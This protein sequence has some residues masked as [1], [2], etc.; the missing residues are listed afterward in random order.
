[1]RFVIS[2]HLLQQN[3]VEDERRPFLSEPNARQVISVDALQILAGG[4]QFISVVGMS[5]SV[6][7]TAACYRG[8]FA[9]H[10]QRMTYGLPSMVTA[11]VAGDHRRNQALPEASSGRV[12]RDRHSSSVL[13]RPGLESTGARSNRDQDDAVQPRRPVG[14]PQFRCGVRAFSALNI[15]SAASRS[16]GAVHQ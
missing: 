8:Y 7:R 5:S 3:A 12:R 10:I 2:S 16:P 6:L 4:H 15:S 11:P 1:M 9:M 13:R 14:V